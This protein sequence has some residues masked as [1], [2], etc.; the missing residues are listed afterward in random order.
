MSEGLRV[1]PFIEFSDVPISLIVES[2][3]LHRV[4]TLANS[5]SADDNTE[6]F[7]S[8]VLY[9]VIFRPLHKY[10]NFDGHK[11]YVELQMSGNCVMNS[12]LLW[13]FQNFNME[14]NMETHSENKY[15]SLKVALDASAFNHSLHIIEVNNN[16]NQLLSL[17]FQLVWVRV[18]KESYN[19][20]FKCCY[21]YKYEGCNN[22]T[23]SWYN[24]VK[25]IINAI[26]TVNTL[27]DDRPHTLPLV[28]ESET[29]M[30]DEMLKVFFGDDDDDDDDDDI[31]DFDDEQLHGDII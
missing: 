9:S 30:P 5:S 29:Q 22:N 23:K 18:L 17:K 21:K 8:H 19:N 4:A 10:I 11:N 7:S 25:A 24:R 14:E 20:I 28:G 15:N 26:E 31:D 6:V 3:I 2:N 27:P 13:I 1:Q 12:L 16:K